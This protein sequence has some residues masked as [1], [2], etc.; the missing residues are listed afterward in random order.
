[1]ASRKA[2]CLESIPRINRTVENGPSTSS[3][4]ARTVS[5]LRIPSRISGGALIWT[6]MD[7]VSYVSCVSW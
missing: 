1:M 6:L 4:A 3:I 5:P 2:A 7:P